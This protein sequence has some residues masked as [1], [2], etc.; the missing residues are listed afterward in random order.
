MHELTGHQARRVRFRAWL[1]N[2]TEYRIHFDSFRVENRS[3]NYTL[4]LG[5]YNSSCS[6]RVPDS[7]KNQ[8]LWNNNKQ[9]TTKDKDNDAM[10]NRNCALIFGGAGWWYSSCTGVSPNVKYCT[11][12]S[13]GPNYQNIKV[14]CLMGETYSMKRF[15]IDLFIGADYSGRS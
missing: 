2:G 6:R 12:E 9:F 15:Q 8:F 11:S 7:C 13:C 5:G 10:N 3:T 1:W 4:R 14:K